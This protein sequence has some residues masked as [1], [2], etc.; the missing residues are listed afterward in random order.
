MAMAKGIKTVVIAATDATH[1]Q[2]TITFSDG[3]TSTGAAFATSGIPNNTIT[4]DMIQNH[5]VTRVKLGTDILPS[6]VG[7]YIGIAN[8]PT[9]WDG[10]GTRPAGGLAPGQV[11]FSYTPS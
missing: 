4:T 8:P 9:A 7:F 3:T 10:T 1:A 6:D 11:Y 2:A 5:Q